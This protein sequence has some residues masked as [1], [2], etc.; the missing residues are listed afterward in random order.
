MLG[1]DGLS[2]IDGGL[3]VFMRP[4]CDGVGEWQMIARR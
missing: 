4:K 3:E 2:R 1:D